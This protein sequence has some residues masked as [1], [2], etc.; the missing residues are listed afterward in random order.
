MGSF[1]GENVSPAIPKFHLKE[2]Q[3]FKEVIRKLKEMD[4]YKLTKNLEALEEIYFTGGEPL[5]IKEYSQLL[6][7]LIHQG[8]SSGITLKYSTNLTQVPD[9]ILNNWTQFKHVQLNVSIDAFQKLNHYIRYPSNWTEITN[10]L[11]KIES[12]KQSHSVSL[13]I[14]CTVQM[15]NI[16]RLREFLLWIK[17]RNYSLHLNFLNEP[18]FLNI[19]V[20]PKNLKQKVDKNSF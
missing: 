12:F 19:C 7:A 16:L 5:L 18:R 20:L 2:K 14:H 8:R 17:K 13:Q 6:E 1:V 9:K 3:R 4:F 10:N 15:Y 11:V